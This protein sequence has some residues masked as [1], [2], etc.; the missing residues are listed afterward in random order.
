[1]EVGNPNSAAGVEMH[2]APQSTQA[3][4][5]VNKMTLPSARQQWSRSMA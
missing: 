1:V 4:F 5:I 2:T 3:V